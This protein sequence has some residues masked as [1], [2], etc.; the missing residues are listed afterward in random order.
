MKGDTRIHNDLPRRLLRPWLRWATLL[1]ATSCAGGGGQ[2][3]PPDQV[4]W[5]LDVV[6]P[7]FGSDPGW[8]SVK[9]FV[10]DRGDP[11]QVPIEDISTVGED[12]GTIE[13]VAD[14][15]SETAPDGHPSV[16]IAVTDLT[17]D[18]PD[19]VL[20]A[21]SDPS[22][23]CSSDADCDQVFS[24]V[25][26]QNR[27]NKAL[28]VCMIAPTQKDGTPCDDGDPCTLA[29]ACSKGVCTGRPDPCDDKNVCTR[30]SCK[31]GTG[32]LHEPTPGFCEDGDFCRGP[33][34]CGDGLCVS[35]PSISCDDKNPCTMDSCEPASGCV[36]LHISGSCDDGN[37]CTVGDRC[38]F[39]T[40]LPTGL[41]NCNDDNPCTSDACLP[42]S[43]CRNEPIEGGCDDNDP[44]TQGDYCKDGKCQPGPIHQCFFCG[45]GACNKPSE[46]CKNCPQDC[47]ECPVDC[48]PTAPVGCGATIQGT[49]VGAS[50]A[51]ES[52]FSLA[53]ISLGTKSGPERVIPFVTNQKVH[54]SVTVTGGG[55]PTGLDVYVL[56]QNC[57]PTSCI[58]QGIGL[59]GVPAEALF[60]PDVG[61]TYYLTV[62]GS[63]Q[64]GA[65]FTLKTQCFEAACGD[66]VDNDQ[67]GATDCA[68][69]DC[70]GSAIACGQTISARIGR[71]SH[72]GAYG[73]ACGNRSGGDDDAVFRL[74]VQTAG[75]VK[76]TV[77]PNDSG[78]DLDVF[79]L[80]GGCT[81]A[82]CV[83]FGASASASEIVTFQAQPG[84]YYFVVEEAYATSES[85]GDFKIQV[86]C[87]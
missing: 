50:N 57:V 68:D 8:E 51:I 39:G 52:Y 83:A 86:Q 6:Y 36:H 21:P 9:D 32:C 28:G 47:G 24:G 14:S 84:T 40:C 67:D 81:G 16:D 87:Q 15:P 77:T 18:R 23:T 45:D 29:D 75:T 80:H 56:T 55:F 62:D 42:A 65:S 63:G 60:D 72:A 13:D 73:A 59:F 82:S 53:C 58:A 70:G 48:E 49:T 71:F 61:R 17:T 30:D 46:N 20:C 85:T 38:E 76:V 19:V 33:D 31:A 54:T 34:S 43:G 12:L 10:A 22:C 25:C 5:G 3:S 78:D 2:G 37:A 79:V 35:G 64:A 74:A 4:V 41:L 1:V 66:S 26:G 11:D 44:C 7:D 27:C 69:A